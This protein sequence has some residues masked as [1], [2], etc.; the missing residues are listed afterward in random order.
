MTRTLWLLV[1]TFALV[2]AACSSSGSAGLSGTSWTVTSIGGQATVAKQPT[3]VFG[4][5]GKVNGTTGCNNYNGTYTISGSSLTISPLATTLMACADPAVN[6]QETVFT[7]AFAGATS[8]AIGSDGNLTL[9]GKTDIVAKP[10]VAA[11]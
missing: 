10:G 2:L 11:G 7:A 6:A 5:D 3:I 9:K 8:W 1:A 4:A